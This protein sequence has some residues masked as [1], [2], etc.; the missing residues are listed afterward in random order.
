MSIPTL[1]LPLVVGLLQPLAVKSSSMAPTI[2]VG[3]SVSIIAYAAGTIPA[4]GD[5][6]ALTSP[7]SGT[8]APFLKRVVGLPGDRIQMRNGQLWINGQPVKQEKMQDFVGERLCG[9]PGV[10]PVKQWHETL[11]NG[12]S[13]QTLDCQEQSALD[14]DNVHTVA[15]GAL[16][17]IGDNRDNSVDSRMPMQMGD[18]PFGKIIGLVERVIPGPAS[19][20]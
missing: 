2:L 16:F 17:V 20:K 10:E 6:V 5:V 3:D 13:Y 9:V 11:P 19:R 7:K 12:V 1:I 18:V 8:S 15:A 4:R 14:N